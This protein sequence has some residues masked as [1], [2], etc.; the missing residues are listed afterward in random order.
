MAQVVGEELRARPLAQHLGDHPRR[1]RRIEVGRRIGRDRAIQGREGR[2]VLAPPGLAQ[3]QVEQGRR[4]AR[5]G[6]GESGE[7]LGRRVEVLKIAAREGRGPPL[8]A[9]GI[10][11]RTEAI[12]RACRRRK[13]IG[14]VEEGEGLRRR[15]RVGVPS[16]R[17][18]PRGPRGERS[19]E[20]QVIPTLMDEREGRLRAGDR[21]VPSQS[22]ADP[23][24]VE[25][26][27]VPADFGSV[28]ESG[29]PS[30]GRSGGRLAESGEGEPSFP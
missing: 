7:D 24:S 18:L 15:A 2:D 8:A 12:R 14:R 29:L 19:L 4:V 1:N 9:T 26:T 21:L 25:G 28:G 16:Q 13:L 17:L 30:F 27:I 23:N 20:A 10:V 3:P 6:P 11:G 22:T 5:I